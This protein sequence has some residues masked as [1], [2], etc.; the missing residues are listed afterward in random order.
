MSRYIVFEGT[1]GCGK[2]TLAKMLYDNIKGEKIFTKEPGSLHLKQNTMIRQIIINSDLQ[3]YTYACLFAADCHEHL[4]KVITPALG[5]GKWVISDRSVLSDFA[6]RPDVGDNVRNVNFEIF[7]N[8]KPIVFLIDA[9][10]DLC[11]KRM[12]ERGPL[13]QFEEL[14]VI[15]RITDIKHGYDL[16]RNFKYNMHL[17]EN[18]NLLRTAFLN[19]MSILKE[20]L[21]INEGKTNEEIEDLFIGD[22][23]S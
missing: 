3:E 5:H 2:T 20:S 11:L 18:N 10:M 13:N 17:V 4:T 16:V 22:D 6:Y 8:L 15:N 12:E 9:E 7:K 21:S 1:D 14:K 19:I 23:Y